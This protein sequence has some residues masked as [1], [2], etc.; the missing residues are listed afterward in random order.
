MEGRFPLLDKRLL[1]SAMRLAP[2]ARVDADGRLKALL[3]DAAAPHLPETVRARRDKMG[4]PLPLGAWLRGA[5]SG[6]VRETLLDRRT[7][8]RGMIDPQGVE[9]ALSEPDRYDRGLY[10]ALSLELWH[11]TFLD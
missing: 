8:A 5:W 4:F 11:R 1:K 2:E 3:K 7:R 9:A 10:A 6:F